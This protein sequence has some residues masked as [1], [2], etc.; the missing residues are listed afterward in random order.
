MA[1]RLL[2]KYGWH[3]EALLEENGR[4]RIVIIRGIANCFNRDRESTWGRLFEAR[5][6]CAFSL[7]K[8]LVV[9][10]RALMDSGSQKSYVTESL[11]NKLGLVPEKTDALNL[12]TFGDDRFGK[13]R[14]SQVRLQLEDQT[15][16]VEIMVIC[17]PKIR[18]PL[19]M[20]LTKPV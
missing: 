1:R 20:T 8:S 16:D 15:K 10:E 17:F 12:N 5:L 9:P 2:G 18:S 3:H 11:K 7:R 14:C 13:Q 19:S 6:T 4:T